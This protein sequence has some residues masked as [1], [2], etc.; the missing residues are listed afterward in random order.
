MSSQWQY[1]TMVK[2]SD[3]GEYQSRWVG[4]CSLMRAAQI[5]NDILKNIALIN[6]NKPQLHHNYNDNEM[7]N[8]IVRITF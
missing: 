2:V 4:G 5:C 8:D 3:S 6:M 1:I 7:C